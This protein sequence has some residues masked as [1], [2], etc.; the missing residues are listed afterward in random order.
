MSK[1]ILLVSMIFFIPFLCLAQEVEDL[2]IVPGFRVEKV[3]NVNR[4][5]DCQGIAFDADGNL[6]V[7]GM[8]WKLYKITPSG[9]VTTLAQF[10]PL[11]GP[12][13]YD[14]E[15]YDG[16][17]YF[18]HSDPRSDPG[19]YKLEG[20]EAVRVTEPGW[21]ISLLAQDGQ[22]NFYARGSQLGQPGQPTGL[23][24]LTPDGSGKFDVVFI[25]ENRPFS[26]LGVR[27]DFVYL[28]LNGGDDYTGRIKK[29]DLNG[30]VIGPDVVTGLNYPSGLEIDSLGN[31]YTSV[32]DE[33]RTEGKGY[34]DYYDVIRISPE[35]V[36]D[37]ENIA[38][39][40]VNNVYLSM[41]PDDVLYI[42]EF[43]EGLIS[44]IDLEG[45]KPY[46]K[47]Y[48]NTDYGLSSPSGLGFDIHGHPYLSSFR[49]S[50]LYRIDPDEKALSPVTEPLGSTNQTIA[51]DE[52]GMFYVSNSY[53][54]ATY[55]INPLTGVVEFLRQFYSRTLEFDSF[56][57]LVV[58]TQSQPGPAYD[59]YLCTVGIM[60]ID[61]P[62]DP[63]YDITSYITPYITGIKNLERGFLFDEDQNFYVKKNRGDGIVKVNVLMDPPGE[64][65]D[66]STTELFVNLQSKD[67]EIRY[68]DR[69]VDGRLLIPLSER[70]ELVLAEPDGSW[71]DFATGF[72]WPGHVN[73]DPNGIAYIVDGDN[74]IFRIIGEEF[75]VPAV[76]KRNQDLYAEISNRVSNKG[77][78]NSLMQKL[79][80]ANKVLEKGNIKAAINI[81]EVFLHEVNAQTGKNISTEDIKYFVT[82]AESILSGLEL[83]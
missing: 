4:A 76:I 11:K 60:D 28:S 3:L 7:A 2:T 23:L 18:T 79:A 15:I 38:E 32:F 22:G 45:T 37:Q 51:V 16:V 78:K 42:S 55:R 33:T 73:F 80:N 5:T 1:R 41:S 17:I 47:S 46:V 70:G 48:V 8:L 49:L 25:I 61:L 13:P 58:T 63:P 24:K 34:Y 74:G 65:F 83:L 77:I 19:L 52:Q 21:S 50:R 67:S 75:V 72:S 26:G 56:R 31:F 40:I 27:G 14:V 54:N 68:F 20:E 69:T 57:R 53:P 64:P 6:I 39:G 81:M 82:I 71:S 35:G 9:E 66:I 29:F 12:N 36:V 62:I 30:D 44:R 10:S 43:S 59:D